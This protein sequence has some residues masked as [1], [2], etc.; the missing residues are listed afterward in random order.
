MSPA[1]LWPVEPCGVLRRLRGSLRPM[2]LTPTDSEPSRNMPRAYI[3]PLA[4]YRKGRK[5]CRRVGRPSL[6]ASEF[7]ASHPT[8]RK[9][10]DSKP[11]EHV[12][13]VLFELFHT[14]ATGCCPN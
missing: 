3:E 1:A 7:C 14:P 5:A 8:Q 9:D 10:A 11:F 4:E 2:T 6:R 12:P 13:K